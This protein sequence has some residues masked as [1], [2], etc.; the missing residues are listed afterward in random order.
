MQL[1]LLN[2]FQDSSV[3]TINKIKVMCSMSNHNLK[4]P[5]L[6]SVDSDNPQEL[7]YPLMNMFGNDDDNTLSMIHILA[8]IV[9][10]RSIDVIKTL[11]DTSSAI[12]GES[13]VVKEQMNFGATVL[14]L[15]CSYSASIG[16][17]N[18]FLSI[19]GRDLVMATD[20]GGSTALQSA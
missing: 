7:H 11:I 18:K 13:T 16:V 9:N 1:Q 4:V 20:F 12:T 17:I 2:F 19:G 5:Q 3:D 15:A 8:C 6:E 14:H 10:N